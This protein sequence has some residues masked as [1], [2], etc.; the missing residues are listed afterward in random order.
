MKFYNNPLKIITMKKILF[1]SLS[2]LVAFSFAVGVMAQTGDT[3][4]RNSLDQLR[5]ER[6]EFK[7]AKAQE[8]NEA[9]Q[10]RTEAT[11]A[12][13][14]A[15][16]ARRVAATTK[17]EEKRK[18]TLL[19]LV[20]VQIKHLNR[21]DERVQKM[22]NITDE[23]KAELSGEIAVNISTLNDLRV[24]VEA[25]EGREAIKALAEEVRSFFGA[26]KETVKSIVS[27]VL[28]SR[29]NGAVATAEE[30]LAA[31]KAK[32]AELKAKG[33]DTEDI[34]EDID[35]A[36]EDID[37][38]QENIGRQAFR[39]ANEDLKGAYQTFREIAQKAK[40]L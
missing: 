1:S 13:R 4:F 38:A 12:R 6:Q 36:E 22:P 9:S 11:Q 34:E 10:A 20:D 8:R 5:Q 15:A 7:D 29:S 33:A 24:R 3:D 37:S 35:D 40:G 19:R 26:Y 23:L 32:V 17:M 25:V 28:A 16:E 31:V 18:T 21:T 27:A 30:R 2:L 14:D 39:E